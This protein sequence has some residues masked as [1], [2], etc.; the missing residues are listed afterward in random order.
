MSFMW[1]ILQASMS[2]GVEIILCF[3]DFPN[4]QALMAELVS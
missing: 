3:K 2:F 4:I 1:W